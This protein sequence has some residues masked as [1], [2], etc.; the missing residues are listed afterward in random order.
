[1]FSIYMYTI[2]IVYIYFQAND[3]LPRLRRMRRIIIMHN[4]YRVV[5]SYFK[6]FR[7]VEML[8]QTYVSKPCHWLIKGE[9]TLL[10]ANKR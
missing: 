8:Y 1:M 7:H 3:E 5:I 6:A 10:L 4:S 2:Y 9:P